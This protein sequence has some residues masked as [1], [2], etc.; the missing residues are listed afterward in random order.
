MIHPSYTE[1]LEVINSGS[2][3]GEAPVV[4]SRYSIVMAAAKRAR[5]I[6]AGDQNVTQKQA[7][8]PL[9][10]AV[11]ELYSGKVRILP[12]SEE[13]QIESSISQVS[14]VKGTGA[15]VEFAE[16]TSEE[17]SDGDSEDDVDW[18]D[19]EDADFDEDDSDDDEDDSDSESE[20]QE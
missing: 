2:E 3:E 4:N 19:D 9:S 1:L 11:S 7:K 5:Q 14:S 8:K 10:T 20:E 15:F 17:K 6:I 12:E 13:D 16:E 18:E